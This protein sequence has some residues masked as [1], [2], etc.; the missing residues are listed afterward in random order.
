MKVLAIAAALLSIDL[1]DSK[2]E[3]ADCWK[4]AGCYYYYCSLCY[5]DGAARDAVDDDCDYYSASLDEFFVQAA[6][7]LPLLYLRSYCPATILLY[8]S[9]RSEFVI[10]L[11]AYCCLAISLLELVMGCCGLR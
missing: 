1:R 4:I 11:F 2:S 5:C 10:L 3:P 6:I 9:V 7:L 8:S